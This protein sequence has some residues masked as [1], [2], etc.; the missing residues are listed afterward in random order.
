MTLPRQ[1]Q[2]AR[3]RN[4]PPSSAVD[5]D[6]SR[7]AAL[8]L[9]EQAVLGWML[10]AANHAE[11]EEHLPD[12]QVKHFLLPAHQEIYGAIIIHAGAPNIAALVAF[13][14][15]GETAHRSVREL[16]GG[17]TGYLSEC[18]DHAD[19]HG[20]RELAYNVDRVKEAF[21]RRRRLEIH[22]RAARALEEDNLAAYDDAM[23]EMHRLTD[24]VQPGEDAAGREDRL[25]RQ[26]I[27][28]AAR[29]RYFS[30]LAEEVLRTRAR[31]EAREI[32]DGEH[33]DTSPLPLPTRLSDLLAEEDEQESWR[34]QG[35]WPSGAHILM[36]A[37]AK[38]GKTTA[39]GNV[40]RC[41][42]DGE[43]FLGVHEVQPV[44]VGRTVAVLDYEMPRRK[45][46]DW[47]R[48]QAIRNV[49]AVMVWTERGNAGRFDPRSELARTLWAARLKS[50]NVAIWIIDCLSPILSA[51]GIQENDNTEVGAVLDG[52]N[53]IAAGAGVDEVLLIHHMG[54][55]A[56]RSRGASRLIGWPD[57]NWKLTRQKDEKDPTAE[58]DPN[59][60]RYF[61]AY[62]RDVDVREGRLLYESESRH[63]TYVEG[64]RKRD[65]DTV[66]L[67]KVLNFVR[68]HPG[69]GTRKLQDGLTVQLG[70]RDTVRKA[71]KV[72]V[73]KGYV[74]AA[75]APGNALEHTITT[76]GVAQILGSS[77]ALATDE[78][79]IAGDFEKRP[80][81]CGYYITP[82][83]W[84]AG[85]RSC[86][87]CLKGSAA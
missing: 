45:V 16:P 76:L 63:L 31:R 62:G 73:D 75:T 37:G 70:G 66:N 61:S 84:S 12:V 47:L 19:L 80:C 8:R 5:Q 39:V 20:P 32:V 49:D 78:E 9:Q 69:L 82:A 74:L 48:D 22:G 58:P 10:S 53:T 21:V 33:A 35:L 28:E 50:A 67:V 65:A 25:R 42:V 23:A 81:G 36:A 15:S 11:I 1:D 55:G 41:L 43:R 44:Q 2:R 51:L 57:V 6:A 64:G 68:S 38:S 13:D 30:V 71:L 56:E 59:S 46:K 14:L 18:K 79:L 29:N 3:H 27:A 83:A 17:V 86:I 77:T 72:A 4:G 60:P 54:H 26:A 34:M 40:I 24:D 7:Q 87:E 52:I 85:A